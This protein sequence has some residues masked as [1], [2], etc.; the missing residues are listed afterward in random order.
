MVGWHLFWLHLQ[1][2]PISTSVAELCLGVFVGLQYR[3]ENY[4]NRDQNESARSRQFDDGLFAP[5][6]PSFLPWDLIIPASFLTGASRPR[7]VPIWLVQRLPR[8]ASVL[9]NQIFFHHGSIISLY[10]TIE[11]HECVLTSLQ[12]N[13]RICASMISELASPFGVYLVLAALVGYYVVPYLQRWHLA[14][15]PSAGFAAWTNLWL[16]LQARQGARFF[17]VDKAHKKKGKIVRIAPNH[18]SIADDA[19]IPVIYGHGN[20]FLKAYVLSPSHL[21]CPYIGSK[22][23]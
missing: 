14:D 17:A 20:G 22:L 2:F 10:T 7:T 16:L 4:I 5:L 21:R 13:L 6:L 15:I 8:T 18:T 9:H 11:W 23:M 19:A 3:G 12:L 1:Y